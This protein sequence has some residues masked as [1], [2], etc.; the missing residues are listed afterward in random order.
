MDYIPVAGKDYSEAAKEW[1]ADLASKFD[2][3][4]LIAETNNSE[5]YQSQLNQLLMSALQQRLIDFKTALEVGRFPFSDQILRLLE[6]KEQEMQQQQAQQQ[7]MMLQGQ[8][9]GLQLADSGASQAEIAQAGADMAV[10]AL[11]MPTDEQALQAQAGQAN[12]RAMEMI[13]QAIG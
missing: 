13:Q 10:Q 8:A 9:A 4:I 3:Y 6:R 2:Y 1:N 11:Q 5:L 7:A 12:P